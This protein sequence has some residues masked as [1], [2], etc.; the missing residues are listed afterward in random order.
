VL[1]GHAPLV[2]DQPG[3]QRVLL[4]RQRREGRRKRINP[5]LRAAAAVAAF[6]RRIAVGLH[7]KSYS[8]ALAVHT[9]HARPVRT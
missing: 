7:I 3:L 6:G 2:L 4:L 9:Q 8:E 1:L 5:L